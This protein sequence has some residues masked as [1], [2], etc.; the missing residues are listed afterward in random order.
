MI[1]Y[2]R[3]QHHPSLISP[4]VNSDNE[5]GQRESGKAELKRLQ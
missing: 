1:H 2:K 5:A 4:I 3:D